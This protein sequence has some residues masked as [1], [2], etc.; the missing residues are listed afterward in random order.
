MN[1]LTVGV[2]LLWLGIGVFALRRRHA[3]VIPPENVRVHL[4]DGR[5]IPC[6][7]IYLGRIGGMHRWE[8]VSEVAVTGVPDA[9][10]HAD[11]IP[12]NTAITV[13]FRVRTP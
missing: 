1:S 7:L 11:M 12:G 2:G 5:T 9:Q 8:A 10:V 13:R 3:Q 6:E 4:T